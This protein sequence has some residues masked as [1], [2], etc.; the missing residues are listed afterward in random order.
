MF[1]CWQIDTTFNWSLVSKTYPVQSPGFSIFLFKK[2]KYDNDKP[3]LARDRSSV[4]RQLGCMRTRHVNMSIFYDLCWPDQIASLGNYDLCGQVSKFHVY[5]L[6][7]VLNLPFS[8]SPGTSQSSVDNVD[9]SN[10]LLQ[11]GP[12]DLH[13]HLGLAHSSRHHSSGQ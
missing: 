9:S 2:I 5:Y 13:L 6:C 12:A 8:T 4:K 10:V 7:P 11:T 1:L 3:L